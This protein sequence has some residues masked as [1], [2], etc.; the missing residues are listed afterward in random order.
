MTC[1]APNDGGMQLPH[2]RHIRSVAVERGA[3]LLTLLLLGC[4]LSSQR[5][6]MP[7]HFDRIGQ[8]A[9]G[10]LR[11]GL[12]VIL[13]EDHWH[14][15]IAVEICYRVGSRDDP[16]GKQGLSLL[17][18]H[19]TFGSPPRA[20]PHRSAS[21]RI[22]REG[23]CHDE[24]D[25][26]C[27]GYTVPRGEFES[28][29][30]LEVRRMSAVNVTTEE[31]DRA[32]EIVARE[33]A[34]LIEGD[35]WRS[36][37]EELDLVAFPVHPYRFPV[38]GWPETLRAIGVEAV[39]SH[40]E[41][42]YGPANAVIAVVGDFR[43][44][45]AATLIDRLFGS[46]KPRIPPRSSLPADPS[47]IGERR[48]MLSPERRRASRS[49]T[50]AATFERGRHRP[51]RRRAVSVVQKTD[52]PAVALALTIPVGSTSEPTEKHGVAAMTAHLLRAGT[53]TRSAR[54]ITERIAELGDTYERDVSFD[55]TVLQLAVLKEDLGPALA[56]L[57][58]LAKHPIFPEARVSSAERAAVGGLRFRGPTLE[59][60][61]VRS[62]FADGGYGAPISGTAESVA[63]ID[64]ADLVTFHSRYYR[65][66]GASLVVAGDASPEVVVD[67]ATRFFAD[68]SGAPPNRR[69]LRP[70]IHAGADRP[71]LLD[72][73]L[74]QASV[75]IPFALRPP[76]IDLAAAHV[77][78]QALGG[79]AD[80]GLGR[81]LRGENSWVYGGR[82]SVEAQRETVLTI[83]MSVS[84]PALASAL[85]EVQ[86]ELERLR[87]SAL[88]WRDL[89]AAKER[90]KLEFHSRTATLRSIARVLA[91]HEVSGATGRPDDILGA[92]ERVGTGDVRRFVRLHLG[93]QNPATAIAGDIEAIRQVAPSLVRE[94]EAAAASGT[95][96]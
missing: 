82:R 94:E 76:P 10:V 72:R 70:E 9:R 91:E 48:M 31:L 23:V 85:A 3:A 6:G 32:R 4:A 90:A 8:G 40:F 17:L 75:M 92:I 35:T 88:T 78:A 74:P 27:Y 12:T 45:E 42:F 54:K 52:A 61:V 44:E 53:A 13:V 18:E 26:T 22:R 96:K 19:L 28:V 34:E 60:T 24:P 87:G 55:A 5:L 15:A 59:E 43:T 64:R 86:A 68:W 73:K 41:S 56:L 57:A 2:T 38:S 33:R 79:G 65:P 20:A 7:V 25:T 89:A 67:A 63:K 51:R 1:S 62:L 16:D 14:P 36:V 95:C 29:L 39:R 77:F 84:Y 11:N 81:R 58:D 69:L 66:S 46:I 21:L 80:S 30:A 50:R 93:Q 71:V 83:G 47:P 37:L 49:P